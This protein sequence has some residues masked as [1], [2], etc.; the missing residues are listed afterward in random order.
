MRPVGGPA[1]SGRVPVRVD[2]GSVRQAPAPAWAETYCATIGGL[3]VAI[4]RLGGETLAVGR[5]CP[6]KGADLARRG[7]PDPSFGQLTCLAHAHTFRIAD[8]GCVRMDECPQVP[9]YVV[10]FDPERDL[11]TAPALPA[12]GRAFEST[13]PGETAA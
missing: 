13:E 3:P 6:H 11:D 9:V 7:L 1:G 10:D 4:F 8:G 5:Y 12:P 2:P